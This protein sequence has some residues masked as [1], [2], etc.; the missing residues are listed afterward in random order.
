MK[1]FLLFMGILSSFLLILVVERIIPIRTI[2]CKSQFGP[3]S[4]FLN[5][6][7]ASI[8]TTTLKETK[9]A[10]RNFLDR[11]I[12]VF[13]Y[14]IKF[15]LPDK[16]EIDVIERKGIAAIRQKDGKYLIFDSK[17]KIYALVDKTALPVIET[18]EGLQYEEN[19]NL[20]EE[21]SFALVFSA[22]LLEKLYELYA[23][24]KGY[25]ENDTLKVSLPNGIEVYFPS[26][27]DISYLLGSLRLILSGL[28]HFQE[29][30][31]IENGGRIR[32]IDLR[33]QN[34]VVR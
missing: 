9:R 33:Y 1:R 16:L 11:Q 4:D 5:S 15:S 17:G 13:D 27:G 25:F 21:V 26:S 23:V 12:G 34:P 14:Q 6:A 3:C 20:G 28:N 19:L 31:K 30:S 32:S 22:S 2:V 8:Q 18:A 29:D 7:L 24:K 10:V